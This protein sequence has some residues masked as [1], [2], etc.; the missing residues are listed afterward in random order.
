VSAVEIDSN[1]TI[2]PLCGC[3]EMAWEECDACGGEGVN[4]HDCGEDCC[5]CLYPEDN[6]PCDFCDGAGGRYVCLGHCI[7]SR[8]DRKEKGR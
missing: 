5:W 7:E 6:V 8:H 3:C 2:C 1:R 4:G